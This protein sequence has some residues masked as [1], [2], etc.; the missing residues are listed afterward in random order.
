MGFFA[1]IGK[2]IMNKFIFVYINLFIFYLF[3]VPF[4]PNVNSLGTRYEI[5]FLGVAF[6]L[7]LIFLDKKSKDNILKLLLNFS[8][9]VLFL[10]LAFFCIGLLS[11]KF[12]MF[13]EKAFYGVYFTIATFIVALFIATYLQEYPQHIKWL[14]L[15]VV[16]CLLSF[17][18]LLL[19]KVGITEKYG[20]K[21][22]LLSS[23]NV[24]NFRFIDDFIIAFMPLLM[25]P[26]FMNFRFKLFL[27][28]VSIVCIAIVCFLI[29]QHGSRAFLFAQLLTILFLFI[30]DIKSFWKYFRV[31]LLSYVL[32]D[33]LSYAILKWIGASAHGLGMGVL[34]FAIIMVC[35]NVSSLS[36]LVN[37][38]RYKLPSS[39][40]R[41][42]LVLVLFLFAGLMFGFSAETSQKSVVLPVADNGSITVDYQ[43]LKKQLGEI[44]QQ[45]EASDKKAI[46]LQ[47]QLVTVSKQN[48]KQ[49]QDFINSQKTYQQK[50]DTLTKEIQTVSQSKTKSEAQLNQQIKSIKTSNENNVAK[51]N[52]AIQ[53]LKK[54]KQDAATTYTK[55]IT[56]RNNS[57]KALQNKFAVESKKRQALQAEKDAREKALSD[58]FGSL[59]TKWSKRVAKN[60]NDRTSLWKH[61]YG[62]GLQ[63]P[64]LGV[65]QWNYNIYAQS[66]NLGYPHDVFLEIWSQWGI[67]AFIIFMLLFLSGVFFIVRKYNL[68]RNIN[69]A[70]VLYICMFISV[71]ADATVSA[72]FKSALGLMSSTIV[73]GLVLSLMAY[74]KGGTTHATTVIK[75]WMKI[76]FNMLLIWLVYEIGIYPILNPDIILF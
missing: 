54:A 63:H 4:Q 36:K 9:P 44:T 24:A 16:L 58:R 62:V 1:P 18:V 34:F 21:Y 47:S 74:K 43:K 45:K 20:A 71:M 25:L 41:L 59:Y 19:H 11:A 48:A 37:I 72:T 13:D 64:W 55:N 73:I 65:G 46:A 10:I 40:V 15:T 27:K 7:S 61:A 12:A 8:K 38:I 31:L 50:I 6:L 60:N 42:S 68:A 17:F 23:Y 66:N 69:P 35:L 32:G 33:L 14:Y 56:A 49:K 28:I 29:I 53:N 67:P 3:I 51:L 22:M 2:L 70:N 52:T 76:A 57:I 39:I 30:L 26:W 5:L 75:P